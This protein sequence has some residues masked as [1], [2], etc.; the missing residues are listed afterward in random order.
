[1]AGPMERVL[2]AFY[3]SIPCFNVSLIYEVLLDIVTANFLQ[4]V[5]SVNFNFFLIEVF[6]VLVIPQ[7]VLLVILFASLFMFLF[8]YRPLQLL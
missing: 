1:M 6:T 8:V 3:N 4:N 5:E 7:N 2:F